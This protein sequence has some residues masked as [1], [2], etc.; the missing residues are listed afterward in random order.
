MT[1]GI[2]LIGA[3]FLLGIIFWLAGGASWV[4][5]KTRQL[6]VENDRREIE[7][8]AKARELGLTAPLTEE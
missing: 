3:I 2:D 1:Q 4:A 8:Q 6:K 5:E 7:N